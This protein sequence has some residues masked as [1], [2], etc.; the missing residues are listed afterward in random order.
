MKI[1]FAI[2]KRRLQNEMSEAIWTF[3]EAPVDIGWIAFYVSIIGRLLLLWRGREIFV[4]H[5]NVWEILTQS[6]QDADMKTLG[7]HLYKLRKKIN[8]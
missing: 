6:S 2:N 1:K 3:L 8:V 5:D 7:F 4:P